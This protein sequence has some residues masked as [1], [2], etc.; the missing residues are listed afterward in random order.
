[1]PKKHERHKHTLNRFPTTAPFCMT[2]QMIKPIRPANAVEATIT[3]IISSF[4]TS[5]MTSHISLSL[6][7]FDKFHFPLGNKHCTTDM[8]YINP[9]FLNPPV[10][11]KTANTQY[12][13]RLAFRPQIP[14]CSF[15]R[16][17]RIA[18]PVFT[19]CGGLLAWLVSRGR[20]SWF[21]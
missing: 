20:E 7:C 5:P 18:A 1:M 14:A 15:R 19:H 12:F 10:D 21:T 4:C 8:V 13:G 6:L 3:A 11:G 2:C 9:S 17:G 16:Q